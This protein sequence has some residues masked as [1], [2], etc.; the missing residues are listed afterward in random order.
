MTPQHKANGYKLQAENSFVL[1]LLYLKDLYDYY[2][3]CHRETI[4]GFQLP[5]PSL[6]TA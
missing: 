4:G 6:A 3:S 5:D 2:F 1:R